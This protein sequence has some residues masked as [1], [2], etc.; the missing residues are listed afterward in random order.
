MAG[1][2]PGGI[3]VPTVT[4]PRFDD[5]DGFEDDMTLP[6]EVFEGVREV[7]LAFNPQGGR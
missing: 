3:P 4:P 6:N 7:E 1:G 2:V 5:D